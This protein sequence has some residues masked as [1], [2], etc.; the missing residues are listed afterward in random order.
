M[1]QALFHPPRVAAWLIELFTPYEQTESIPGDL[2]EEFSDLASKSGA[3]CA[4]RWFWRQTVPTISHLVRGGFQAA[5]WS[6]AGVVFGGLLLAQLGHMFSEWTIRA[7]TQF[8]NHHYLPPYRHL[9][10]AVFSLNGGMYLTRLMVSALI[11]CIV[12]LISKRKEVLAT[13][14]L[15]LICGIWAIPGFWHFWHGWKDHRV[16]IVLPVLLYSFGGSFAIVIGGGI[17][18]K[19]RFRSPRPARSW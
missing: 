8:F 14:T 5:P 3:A 16:A 12:A 4:R 11:G 7:G 6:T 13:V 18:R 9:R 2:L 1:T 10:L 15:S 17:V 19:F